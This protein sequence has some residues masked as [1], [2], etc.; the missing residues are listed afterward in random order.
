[1]NNL[2]TVLVIALL[3]S[4]L[5][6]VSP[7]VDR[8]ALAMPA[9]LVRIQNVPLVTQFAPSQRFQWENSNVEFVSDQLGVQASFHVPVGK[10]LV[11][12]LVSAEVMIDDGSLPNF[13]VN[14]TV[15]G[16]AV[17]HRLR[18][19]PVGPCGGYSQGYNVSQSLR[20]YADPGTEVILYAGRTLVG[21]GVMHV[22]VSGYLVNAK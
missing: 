2:P 18:P 16:V 7:C 19:T 8:N 5:L 14:T 20:L 6:V 10:Y 22:G 17:A 12:E 15:N 4:P 11:L 1:M 13:S 3:I 9:E 21:R